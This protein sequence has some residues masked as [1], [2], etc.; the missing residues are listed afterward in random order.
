MLILFLGRSL[1]GI[2]AD[3]RQDFPNEPVLVVARDGD[4][5]QPPEG[6]TAVEASKFQPEG[7][8]EYI[9]IANGGT[10]VQLVSVLKSLVETKA[11]MKVFDLQRDGISQLW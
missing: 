1:D 8:V 11:P 10:A 9:V 2:L 4:Q 7:G 3:A 6:M 5:L